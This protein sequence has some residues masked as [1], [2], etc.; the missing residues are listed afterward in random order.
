MEC[1]VINMPRNVRS[2]SLRCCLKN[3]FNYVD[4]REETLSINVIVA[5]N[6]LN[7]F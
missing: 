4:W 1:I 6:V 3:D 5:R 2:E 7:E